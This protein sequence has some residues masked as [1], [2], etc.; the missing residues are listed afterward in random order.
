MKIGIEVMKMGRRG[1][2]KLAKKAL[3]KGGAARAGGRYIDAA[4]PLDGPL[5]LCLLLTLFELASEYR[6]FLLFVSSLLPCLQNS[7]DR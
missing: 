4:R 2:G 7:Q 3:E 1:G 5:E 6:A